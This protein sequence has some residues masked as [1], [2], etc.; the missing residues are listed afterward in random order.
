MKVI[1][2]RPNGTKRVYTRNDEPSKTDQSFSEEVNVN[3]IMA[4]YIKTGQ[5]KHLAKNVGLYADVSEIPDLAEALDQVTKAQY[6]FD[7]LPS[8]LRTRFQNS[9]VEMVN[10]LS[11]NKNYDEAVSLGLIVKPSPPPPSETQELISE[12]KKQTILRKPAKNT[13]DDD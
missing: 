11:D 4:K 13:N 9:P 5:I 3:N 7:A 6:A 10:F 1:E 12:L 2:I 8:N